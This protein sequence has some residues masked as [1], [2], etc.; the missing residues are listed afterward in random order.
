MA[1]PHAKTFFEQTWCGIAW[2]DWLPF[3]RAQ[4]A[5]MPERPGLYR[6]RV[7]GSE[8]LFY[9]FRSPRVGQSIDA[10][11]PTSATAHQT[12]RIVADYILFL[13]FQRKTAVARE[14]S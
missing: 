4:M 1:H 9:I 11:Q 7:T 2:S 6:L 10:E 3:T 8:E 13:S 5:R 14:A 12:A